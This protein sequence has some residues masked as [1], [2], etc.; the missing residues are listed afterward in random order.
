MKKEIEK[1]QVEKLPL[2]KEKAASKQERCPVL[3]GMGAV[4]LRKRGC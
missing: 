3:L 1:L 4:M 2:E